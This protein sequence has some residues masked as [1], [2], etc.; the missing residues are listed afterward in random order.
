MCVCVHTH[1][2]EDQGLEALREGIKEEEIGGRGKEN[3]VKATMAQC[4]TFKSCSTLINLWGL[5][6]YIKNPKTKRLGYL[7]RTIILVYYH[8][9]NLI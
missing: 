3:Y 5:H 2:Y 7:S 8:D 9:K 4:L 6:I 1:L